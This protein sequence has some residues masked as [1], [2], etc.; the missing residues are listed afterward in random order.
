MDSVQEY[1]RK[2]EEVIDKIGQPIKPYIP[3]IA[4]FLIVVTFLEDALRI[5][6]QFSDQLYY[7]QRH[8]GFPWG[9]SHFFLIFN[10]LTMLS[11]STMVIARKHTEYAAA[12]LF[13]VVITQA[14]GYGLIFDASFFLR[15]LSVIGGLLMVIS[16][17]LSK[18]RQLFAGLPSITENNKRTYFQL[19]GRVLL[20]FL[21]IGFALH[22]SWSLTR[23]IGSI[24]GFA[25]CVMIAIGFKAKWSAMFLVLFLSVFNIVVNNWW[26]VDNAHMQKDFLKYDFFQT[27]SIMGGLLLLVTIGPGGMSMDEKKKAF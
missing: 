10:V 27:L 3:A 4:R 7:L 19:A 13:G 11:C 2:F 18:R 26:S 9:L 8:R 17:S 24:I 20:I 12:A 1:S 5:M 22:G 21:F 6:T 14:L 16:D 25:A 15:N 23:V